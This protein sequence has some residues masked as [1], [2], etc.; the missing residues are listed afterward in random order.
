MSKE[1]LILKAKGLSQVSKLSANEY[2]NKSEILVSHINN[3]LFLRADIDQLVG[4][5]NL[6]MAKDNHANHARFMHSIFQNFDA[7]ILVETILWVFRAYRSHGFRP[8][9]W[10][11][12]LN[13]WTEVLKSELSKEA[14]QE[15]VPYYEWMLVNIPVFMNL[16]EKEL[17]DQNEH[18]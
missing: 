18:K 3:K 6:E 13:L 4:K 16:S 10:S 2:G 15:I 14:F 12:Q 7:E 9:Y 5:N 1:S 17:K 8:S 11:A